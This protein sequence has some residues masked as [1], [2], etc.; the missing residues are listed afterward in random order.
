MARPREIDG[1]VVV[2]LRSLPVPVPWDGI[3]QALGVSR[4]GVIAAFRR[5]R[6]GSNDPGTC[7]KCLSA[8]VCPSGCDKESR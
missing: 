7:E 4:A 8:K 5:E 2:R 1:K 3:A 6:A